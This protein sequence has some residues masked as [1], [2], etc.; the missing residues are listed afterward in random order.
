[1]HNKTFNTL[2][3]ILTFLPL[4]LTLFMLQILPDM[5]PAH[6]GSSGL[7]DRWGSKY[8]LLI[9][10]LIT[11]VVMF[12]IYFVMRNKQMEKGTYKTL[13]HTTISVLLLFNLLTYMLLYIA[14]RQIT[15]LNQIKFYDINTAAIS[16]MFIIIGNIIPKTK[17]NRFIGFRIPWTLASDD[18]W[19]KTHR[20]TGKLFVLLGFL[21][22][23]SI[24]FVGGLAGCIAVLGM[25]IVILIV[26]TFYSYRLS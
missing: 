16:I 26:C 15:D 8:E 21:G 24:A 4:A 20:L 2:C 18:V 3:L 10:P 11:L 9:L 1:M 14:Y 23:G 25:M 22:L 19:H 17:R 12:G 6:F 7:A 5:I 13:I